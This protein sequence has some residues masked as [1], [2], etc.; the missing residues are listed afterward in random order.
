MVIFSLPIPQS[1]RDAMFMGRNPCPPLAEIVAELEAAG[2]PEAEAVAA[3]VQSEWHVG[4]RVHGGHRVC[5]SAESCQETRR[6][7]ETKSR[8]LTPDQQA[9]LAAWCSEW[10]AVGVDSAPADRLR[11]E[12]AI[13]R[14]YEEIGVPPPRFVWVPSPAVGARV[15]RREGLLSAGDRV[16][17]DLTLWHLGERI[18]DCLWSYLACEVWGG[19]RDQLQA[20]WEGLRAPLGAQLGYA[21]SH[22][23]EDEVRRAGFKVSGWT[24]YM[25]PRGQHEAHWLAIH[26]FAYGVLGI[27]YPAVWRRRIDLLAEVAR[28]CNRWWPYEGL[29][30]ICDRPKAIRW[31]PEGRLHGQ[32][33]FAVEFRDGEGIP[34]WHGTWVPAAWITEPESVHPEVALTWPNLEQRRVAAEIVGWRRVLEG[35]EARTVDRDADPMIGEL[36]EVELPGAGPARFLK[37][38]CPTGRDFVLSVPLASRSARAANAWTYGLDSRHYDLEVRT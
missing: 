21:V 20:A 19:A 23:L 7:S 15:L 28:S 3:R 27:F 29:C 32:T 13:A 33:R 14:L 11:A 18:E 4:W 38:R 31:D 22:H 35:L 5:S 6:L 24:Y 12:A 37:V 10:K 8:A 25:G 36:L 30:V 26:T 34:I 16:G 17:S 2:V 1:I 9:Q